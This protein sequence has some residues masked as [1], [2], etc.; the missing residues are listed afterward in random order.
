MRLTIQ[1]AE[2]LG[3][4]N[5]PQ[6]SVYRL[7]ALASGQVT[8]ENKA[9]YY[10]TVYGSL[11]AVDANEASRDRG[12]KPEQPQTAD[13]RRRRRHSFPTDYRL[14]PHQQPGRGRGAAR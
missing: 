13:A 11:T 5:N 9:A 2:S 7:L 4:K 10:P 14:W 12:R 6:I 8:R 1:D 3:L